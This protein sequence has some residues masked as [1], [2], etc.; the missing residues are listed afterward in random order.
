[1]RTLALG[2]FAG[3]DIAT[4][5]ALWAAEKATTRVFYGGLNATR[6]ASLSGGTTTSGRTFF[7]TDLTRNIRQD[8][9]IRTF[10]VFVDDLGVAPASSLRVIVGRKNGASY[11]VVGKS[12]YLTP[13]GAGLQTFELATPIACQPGDY[14]GLWVKGHASEGILIGCITVSGSVDYIATESTNSSDVYVNSPGAT[15][16]WYGEGTP[17]FL[18]LAGES[19]LAGHNGASIWET[20]YE[21]GPAGNLNAEPA[22]IIRTNYLAAL[23]YQNFC[24]GGTT[25]DDHVAKVADIAAVGAKGVLVAGGVNDVAQGRS[26]A[27][28][29]S[30]MN[31][32]KAGMPIGTKLFIAEMLPYTP[33]TNLEVATIRTFNANYAS[34]CAANDATLIPVWAAMG[35]LRVS[36]GFNDDMISA[37]HYS[38]GHLT[39]PAGVAAYAVLLAN[40][41]QSAYWP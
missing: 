6:T 40:V 34:W 11:D 26:W 35:Q 14:L 10:K 37:Y 28:I 22:H 3:Y 18:V 5:M 39:D 21:N 2:P 12:E 1:M 7:N 25:W 8:G 16:C 27:T 30:E 13:V 9:L 17:P 38:G 31:A 19:I 4:R 15:G 23:E 24:E 36:T 20:L 41:L 33:G 29:E 32:F